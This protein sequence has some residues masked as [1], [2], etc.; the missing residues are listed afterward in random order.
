MTQEKMLT[1]EYAYSYGVTLQE[2]R[3][4]TEEEK[5]HYVEHFRDF[6]LVGLSG[7]EVT[8]D[9]VSWQD[10]PKRPCDGEFC[11]SAN[12]SWIITRDEWDAY[13]ALNEKRLAEKADKERL[14]EIAYLK[15]ELKQMERQGTLCEN[16]DEARRKEREW[17]RIYNEGGEGY[18]P[19]Y[20]TV[21]EYERA[22]T[23]LAELEADRA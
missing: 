5:T 7:T 15:S 17:N 13:V 11:G 22:K 12:R 19:H 6:G 2:A 10:M 18:V 8:L 4:F 23:R 21:A 1:I 9:G 3:R 20:Y 16:R 14:E